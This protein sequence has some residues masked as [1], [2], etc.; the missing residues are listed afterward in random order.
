[1]SRNHN[2]RNEQTHRT[3]QQTR[4]IIILPG[5]GN[6][7]GCVETVEVRDRANGYR[8]KQQPKN[9]ADRQTNRLTNTQT[10]TTENNTT[11]AVR[12]VKGT[13]NMQKFKQDV[14][15]RH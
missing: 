10:G 8:N 5:G 7:G 14:A 4:P 11:L 1:M 2:E 15:L 12:V 3:N 6:Y 9:R 13:Q